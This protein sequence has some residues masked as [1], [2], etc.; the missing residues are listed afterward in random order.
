M[1]RDFSFHLQLVEEEIAVAENGGEEI[2]EVVRNAA[3]ELAE[4][5][6]LL[7]A[8]ELVL[9]LFARRNVHERT[10]ELHGPAE[11]IADDAGALEQ[12][13]IRAIQMTEA[14]FASPMVVPAGERVSDAGGGASAVLGMK[15]FLPE[16]DIV[17]GSGRRETEK[18]FETLGPGKRAGGYSP[19]PNSIM[20]SLGSERKMLRDFSRAARKVS[21]NFIG[22]VGRWLRDPV[23]LG[24][25]VLNFGR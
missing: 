9:E 19:N 10:D 22:L 4:R 18:R 15:L 17:G 7:R 20:R 6:H 23:F 8:N 3:G 25:L 13:E 16:T 1:L 21:R 2:I 24:C 14:I 11:R 5:F 12:I